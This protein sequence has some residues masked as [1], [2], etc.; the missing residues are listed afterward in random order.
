MSLVYY[1][2]PDGLTR[3]A[4]SSE[5]P[6]P[7]T[8][9]LTAP[10]LA[11][12]AKQDEII[13]LLETPASALPPRMTGARNSAVSSYA[14]NTSAAGT[15]TIVVADVDE[16]WQLASCTLSVGGATTLTFDGGGVDLVLDIPAAGVLD[17]SHDESGH[18]T[19]AINTAFTFA[20]SAAVAVK[21]V[22]KLQKGA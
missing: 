8:G 13:T 10:G 15:T 4:A 12:T 7:V 18:A 2:D 3:V 17:L 14:V 21:G 1:L 9:S 11:T 5:T 20:S 6:L 16:A 19:G 22:I